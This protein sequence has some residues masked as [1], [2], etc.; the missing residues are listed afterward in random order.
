MK[1]PSHFFALDGWRG[2]AAI[3]VALFHFQAVSTCAHWGLVRGSWLAVDLFFLLSGFVIAANYRHRLAAGFGV[4]RFMLLRLGR[5][6]PLHFILLFAFVVTEFLLMFAGAGTSLSGREFFA[7]QTAPHGLVTSLLLIQSIGFSDGPV[8]NAVAWSISTEFWMYLVY[9]LA[10]LGLTRRIDAAMATLI[11]VALLFLAAQPALPEWSARFIDF[12]R[13]VYGFALGTMLHAAYE[14][15]AC[16]P[17]WQPGA[18]LFT[19]FELVAM[20]T[21]GLYVSLG[22]GAHVH[23][24][25]PL[26]FAPLIIVYAFD[27]GVFS[28]ILRTPPF[29]YLGLVSYSIYMVHPFLQQRVLMPL[30]LVVERLTGIQLI[31]IAEHAGAPVRAWGY[32]TWQG[33][34]ATILM[35]ACLLG[36]SWLTYHF[37]EAPGRDWMRR[38]V[39]RGGGAPRRDQAGVS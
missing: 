34:L 20:V 6:Y 5:I 12:A 38:V 11:A 10:V 29:L 3:L 22:I 16:R 14:W 2:V 30:G 19:L 36:C 26:V 18:A 1:L 15:I 33:N 27:A 21:A 24:L 37:I 23:L 9:A 28:R 35:L 31:S 8:W 7:G 17:D 13:C 4:R 32:T 25:A 39:G